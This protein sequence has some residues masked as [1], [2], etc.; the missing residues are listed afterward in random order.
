MGFQLNFS[1]KSFNYGTFHDIS[2]DKNERTRHRKEWTVNM[3]YVENEK[4]VK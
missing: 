2:V 3:N 4:K 1:I